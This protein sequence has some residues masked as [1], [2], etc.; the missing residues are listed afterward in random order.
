MCN[1]CETDLIPAQNNTYVTL[2]SSG[3]MQKIDHAKPCCHQ[4]GT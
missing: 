1:I 4:I 2:Y 3:L